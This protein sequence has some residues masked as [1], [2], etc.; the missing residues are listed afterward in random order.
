M[1]IAYLNSPI[2]ALEIISNDGFITAINFV[3]KLSKDSGND[4]AIKLCKDELMAYFN[5]K[6]KA[7]SVKIKIDTT[8]FRNSVYNELLGIKFG[9]TIS[10]KELAKRAGN[11]RAFRAA[12]SAN[13]NN[14]IPIIVPCHRVVASNNGLGGYSGADG[15]KTKIWLLKHEGVDISKL[16]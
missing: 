10:Y 14:P 11:E 3:Q 7:F 16:K 15:I 4:P 8:T 13:A 12:A 6:L 5:G 1:A 9:E 2:G